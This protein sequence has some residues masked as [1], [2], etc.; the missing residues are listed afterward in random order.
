MQGHGVVFRTDLQSVIITQ[1]IIL[2]NFLDKLKTCVY[3]RPA[4]E[5]K[6]LLFE[7][8]LTN[9]KAKK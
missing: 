2:I 4:S 9:K 3:L 6:A 1:S 8:L 7:D 5:K